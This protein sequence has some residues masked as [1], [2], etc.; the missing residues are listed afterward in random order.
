MTPQPSPI[1]P[2]A[3]RSSHR[4]PSF[5]PST[6]QRTWLISSASSPLSLRIAQRALAH[7]DNVVGGVKPASI[8]YNGDNEIEWAEFVAGMGIEED[9]LQG[10]GVEIVVEEGE[11][12]DENKDREKQGKG[13]GMKGAKGGKRKSKE[14][15]DGKGEV[16]NGVDGEEETKEDRKTWGRRWRSVEWDGR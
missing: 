2:N 11:G 12:K 9:G 4:A 7:G 15:E 16:V 1:T 5:P 3:P 13:E 6:A 14:G 10:A 8:A